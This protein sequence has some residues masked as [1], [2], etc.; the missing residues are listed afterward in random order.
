MDWTQPVAKNFTDF[1][2]NLSSGNYHLYHV[3]NLDKSSS[4]KYS[5][6]TPADGEVITWSDLSASDYHPIPDELKKLGEDY[7]KN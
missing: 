5:A 6:Y 2:A 1:G 3:L 4:A 7:Y